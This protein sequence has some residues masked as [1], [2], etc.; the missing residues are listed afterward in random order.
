MMMGKDRLPRQ[1]RDKHANMRKAH[2]KGGD[3]VLHIVMMPMIRPDY[4]RDRFGGRPLL[5]WTSFLSLGLAQPFV[6]AW[7]T[8]TTHLYTIIQLWTVWGCFLGCT[9]VA[10]PLVVASVSQGL[11][12]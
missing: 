11:T 5:I 2:V 8:G 6:Y 9:Y 7:L 3:Q 12:A 4:W 10:L 1:A